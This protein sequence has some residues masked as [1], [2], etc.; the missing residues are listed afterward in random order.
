M[1]DGYVEIRYWIS[2]GATPAQITASITGALTA[3]TCA[4]AQ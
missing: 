1:P 4:Y 2:P 3:I